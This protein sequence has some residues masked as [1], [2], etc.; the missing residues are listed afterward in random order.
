M[1]DASSTNRFASAVQPDGITPIDTDKLDI[2]ASDVEIPT[3]DR[4]IPGY[5]ARPEG[6]GPF[7]ILL[8]VQ[9][10][11]GVHEHIR[12]VCRRFAKRGFL[13]VAPELYVRQGDTSTLKDF[14]AIMPIVASV[15]DAQVM[16]D[17]D[18]AVAWAA[19]S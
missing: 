6:N 12:D 11:F 7:P 18:A 8:V 15:P 4:P 5:S 2:V 19:S 1:T 9:E 13:A 10:I 17:L 16:T 3:G 14:S